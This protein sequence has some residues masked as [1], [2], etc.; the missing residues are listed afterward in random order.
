MKLKPSALAPRRL[1]RSAA[2]TA[3]MAV[4]V[5]A[6]PA[7]TLTA[8]ADAASP[9]TAVTSRSAGGWNDYSCKPSTAHP[10]PVVLV[11]G[12]FGNS[13]D[14]WLGLAPYLVERGYCVFSLD[15]GQLPG[16]PFFHGLGPI[17]DSAKQLAAYVDKVLAATGTEKVDI[18]GHS[19]G[20]MMPRQYLKFLG[21]APKV[22]AL[23]G[24][25]PS[26]HGTTLSG[27]ARLADQFPPIGDVVDE[28][29]PAL[30]QQ[31]EGSDFLK[32]L[33]AG[34]D[35]VPGVK[36]TVIATRYDQVVTPY[37]TQFLDGPNV[38]NV[39]LQDLCPLNISEHLAVAL[40]DRMAWH[41]T[42]N[43]LDPAHA[44]PTTCLS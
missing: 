26:N 1:R 24:I 32:K 20:G 23:I 41:E 4:A 6:L 16:K 21:G 44:T 18:V 38:K 36:Y 31:K 37:K 15:Y 8:P 28:I 12:T 40:A 9:D 19:Q 35:T 39:T 25:A 43:A 2:T 11:H 27:L 42:A 5:V 34:G 3:A 29:G 14:N 10:R 7:A 17:E 30:L 33:N 13:V 22:N